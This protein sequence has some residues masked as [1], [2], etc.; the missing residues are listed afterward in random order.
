MINTAIRQHWMSVLAHSPTS[1]LTELWQSL[2]LTPEYHL[3]RS[4]EVGL[5][6]VQGRMGGEGRR[7]FM[8][9]VTV[10]RAVVQLSGDDNG[11]YGYSYVIG[12]NKAHAEL[13]A[14]IDAL[15]QIPSQYDLLQVRLI[16][17]LHTRLTAK[18]QQRKREIA[19]SQVDF[20]TLVRG[21]D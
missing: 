20:F 15:L 2:N 9:D 11:G 18:R 4:P 1:E 6:Q 8:G 7:F 16:T 3:I 5:L 14:L 19:T 10:T 12:R 13:S 21:E 17:P